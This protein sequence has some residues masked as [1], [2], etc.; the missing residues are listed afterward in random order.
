[1]ARTYKQLTKDTDFSR[2]LQQQL[3]NSTTKKFYDEEGLKLEIAYMINRLRRE[4]KLTQDELAS[5]L[6]TTQSVIA[7]IEQGQQN[8]T[9]NTLQKLAHVFEKNLKVEF[10]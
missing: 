5:K 8:F 2:Y 3:K 1:M 10:A 6:Q 7:R 9:L 4:H